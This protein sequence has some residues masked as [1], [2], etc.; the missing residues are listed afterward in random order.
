MSLIPMVI[1]TTGRTERAY[2]IY[3]RLLKDRIILLG[4]PVDDNVASLICAQ[5]L[6]LESQDPE[7]EIN[8]YIN[9]PGGSVTA[10]MAIFDTMRYIT[11]PIS[12]VCMGAEAL[13]G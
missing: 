11:S 5:L 8:L 6:F 13:N 12:T 4:S 2:D 3:S 7:K 9:S 10:G 1:E